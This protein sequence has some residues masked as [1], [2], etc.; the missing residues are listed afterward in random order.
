MTAAEVDRAKAAILKNVEL[1]LNDASRVG[2]QMSEW[3]AQG[4]WRLFYIYRDR[5]RAVTPADVNRVAQAYLKPSNRTVGAFVPTEKPD[6]SD[7]PAAPSIDS[8]V[9]DYKGDALV[10][11][12]EAFDP[13]PEIIVSRVKRIGLANGF[14][15]ALL[16]KKTRGGSVVV[17]ATFRFGDEKSLFGRTMDAS[18]A[19]AMLMRGSTTHT[20]QQIRE[21]LDRLKARAGVESS[22]LPMANTPASG[23]D[24]TR[25]R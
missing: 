11:A 8:L 18:L 3:I 19:G 5:I 25:P 23:T 14:Q 7:I 20:R 17:S 1:G 16:P 21:E 4:D 15:V 24:T 9:K 22:S 12:G 10:A 2:L 6:R 13:S